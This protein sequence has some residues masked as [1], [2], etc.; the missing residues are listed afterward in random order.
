MGHDA[1]AYAHESGV[2]PARYSDTVEA[3][4]GSQAL[5]E[6]F[7][8]TAQARDKMASQKYRLLKDR[9]DIWDTMEKDTTQRLKEI[10]EELETVYDR[11]DPIFG[12]MPYEQ[13]MKPANVVKI[14]FDKILDT[15]KQRLENHGVQSVMK[16]G[17]KG[18]ERGLKK[19]T[20][21]YAGDCSM[22]S[23]MVRGTII[24][25]GTIKDLYT[26]LSELLAMPELKSSTVALE[27]IKDRYQVPM[28]GGYRDISLILRVFGMV[29]ELQ[30]NLKEVVDIKESPAGH[31]MYE[32]TRL[33]NDDL[34]YAAMRG[35]TDRVQR[36]LKDGADANVSDG[37]FG[38]GALSF[39]AVTGDMTMVT[40]LLTKGADPCII[41]NLGILPAHRSAQFGFEDV[42][43]KIVEAMLKKPPAKHNCSTK[44]ANRFSEFLGVVVDNGWRAMAKDLYDWWSTA[45]AMKP[46]PVLERWL[47]L[48]WKTTIVRASDVFGAG[49]FQYEVCPE[50]LNLRFAGTPGAGEKDEEEDAKMLQLGPSCVGIGDEGAVSV[51]AALKQIQSFRTLQL[52]LDFSFTNNATNVAPPCPAP[53]RPSHLAPARPP[54]SAPPHSASCCIMPLC[55]PAPLR[56]AQPGLVLYLIN[57]A[58]PRILVW[59]PGRMH[60]I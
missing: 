60:E 54:R 51:A 35:E 1:H 14:E 5:K 39:G 33:L 7:F 44:A 45:D 10:A 43:G 2:T 36:C 37:R 52:G 20:V 34:L 8:I 53:F 31:G 30:L 16:T 46:V 19:V 42:T 48:G 40:E 56:T 18:I 9:K 28:D 23:D 22:L 17:L 55:V 59:A 4:G 21:D 41:D 47:E 38:I 15:I 25:D 12:C 3:K 57:K 58:L 26:V 11:Q 50:L 27:K 29:C 6:C 13:M 49:F 24:I 32:K